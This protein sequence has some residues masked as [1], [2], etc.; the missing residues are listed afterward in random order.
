MMSFADLAQSAT[1]TTFETLGV[2]ATYEALVPAVPEAF[3]APLAVTLLPTTR[4]AVVSGFNGTSTITDET[5]FEVR[6]SELAA[7]I[8]KS[9]VTIAGVIYR[10]SSA[11]HRRDK[12][13]L[14]WTFGCRKERT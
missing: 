1:D 10:I 14:K 13:G 12:R 8:V 7:P 2:A 4:D 3:A 11:P 5:W 6:V 9:R